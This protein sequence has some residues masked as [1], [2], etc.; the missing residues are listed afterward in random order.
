VQFIVRK[1]CREV[2]VNVHTVPT[3]FANALGWRENLYGRPQGDFLMKGTAGRTSFVETQVP[4][5]VV[6]VF[7]P[8]H[9]C[10]N[11]MKGKCGSTE[12]HLVGVEWFG[13][14]LIGQ[15]IEGCSAQKT[16]LPNAERF[17]LSV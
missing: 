14:P 17:L 5:F 6:A 11:A 8:L 15:V 1:L 9:D 4:E 3:G 13:A 10:P 12:G 16:I 2:D 7:P